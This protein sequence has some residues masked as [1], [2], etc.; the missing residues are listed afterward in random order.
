MVIPKQG[1]FLPD[2]SNVDCLPDKSNVNF[3][4]DKSNVDK[5]IS[6]LGPITRQC[7]FIVKVNA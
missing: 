3:L 7:D 4:P 2:K 1:Y 5:L 6:Y